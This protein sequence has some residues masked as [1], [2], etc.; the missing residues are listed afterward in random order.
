M[1]ITYDVLDLN[2]QGPRCTEG[3]VARRVLTCF[4]M[5]NVWPGSELLASYPTGMLSCLPCKSAVK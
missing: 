2:I 5:K 3:P 1:N 4:I